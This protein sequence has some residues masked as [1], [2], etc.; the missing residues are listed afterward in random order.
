MILTSSLLND[1]FDDSEM[2]F[3][4][5]VYDL[6]EKIVKINKD[7]KLRKSIG[8]KGGRPKATFAPNLTG[9]IM[10]QGPDPVREM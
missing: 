3:Y 4:S 7:E 10:N 2:I 6:S 8:K 5:N 9:T 1:F